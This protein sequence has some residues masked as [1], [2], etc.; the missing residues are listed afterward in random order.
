[1]L[2]LKEGTGVFT[3]D[4]RRV[5]DIDRIVLDPDTQEVTHV[6]V[7]Q[8]WLLPE[9]KVLPMSMVRSATKDR[10]VL[11]DDAPD[12]EQLPPFESQHF[13]EV[14]NGKNPDGSLISVG[15]QPSY[16]WY[17]PLGYLGY[18]AYGLNPNAWPPIA[19]QRNIPD[20]TVALREGS[21]VIGSDGK[22]LGHVER[23][24]LE[25]DSDKVSHLLI[26]HGLLPDRKLIPVGWVKSVEE[27][28]VQLSVP[29]GV[30]R[31]LRSY[32]P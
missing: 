14:E 8:G 15:W 20:Y 27:D 7:K 28:R 26:S 1:M 23:L 3:P 25:E 11:R 29:S 2:Q 21:Q 18:P 30:V 4:G 19:T 24:F 10:V 17:P 32:E 5:G 12:F 9:D 22:H 6:V 31:G 16:Y 13:V